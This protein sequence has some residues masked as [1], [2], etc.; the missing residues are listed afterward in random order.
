MLKDD[1]KVSELLSQFEEHRK[2]IQEMIQHIEAIRS[3]VDRLIPDKLDA[4]YIRFFEEKVKSITSLFSTIL[5]MRKEIAKS[6]KDEIEIRR[7]MGS[8]DDITKHLEDLL[9]VRS[10]ANEIDNFK[11]E[12]ENQKKQRLLEVVDDK[13]FPDVFGNISK[14]EELNE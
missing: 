5:D 7:K 9:D 14:K 6:V 4:R 1:D 2:A 3:K 8:A 13:N 11:K 12:V 10:L